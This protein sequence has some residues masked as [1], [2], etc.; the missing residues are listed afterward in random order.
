[1]PSLTST[2]M[3]LGSPISTPCSTVMRDGPPWWASQP[4][5]DPRRNPSRVLPAHDV[6]REGAGAPGGRIERRHEVAAETVR[7]SRSATARRG[8]PTGPSARDPGSRRRGMAPPATSSP[9]ET[10]CAGRSGCASVVASPNASRTAAGSTIVAELQRTLPQRRP[11]AP[12]IGCH[13]RGELLEPCWSL[14]PELGRREPERDGHRDRRP[15]GGM[16]SERDLTRHGPDAMSIRGVRRGRGGRGALHERGLGES[17]PARQLRH[18]T[19]YDTVRVE[20]HGVQ[21]ALHRP[22]GEHIEEVEW[23]MAHGASL[24]A[25]A[26]RG[27]SSRRVPLSGAPLPGRSSCAGPWPV[28]RAVAGVPGRGRCAGPWLSG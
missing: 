1:M 26:C 22:F 9:V 3:R 7:G 28:C 20:D 8:R 21:V 25:A 5:T 23:Q 18:L 6:Q 12:A 15:D 13:R 17:Q 14:L 10:S 4:R 11:A 19:I 24:R 27:T 16:A 2:S